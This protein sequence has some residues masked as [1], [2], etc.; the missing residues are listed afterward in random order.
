M[1]GVRRM[2]GKGAPARI[3]REYPNGSVLY[4]WRPRPGVK[5][6]TGVGP[7]GEDNL[8]LFRAHV[9]CSWKDDVA[10]TMPGEYLS[11]TTPP[12]VPITVTPRGTAPTL[13]QW[14]GNPAKGERGRFFAYS[15]PMGSQNARQYESSFRNH[16]AFD[17]IGDIPMDQ[18]TADNVIAILDR[19]LQCPLCAD[20]AALL[21]PESVIPE[22]AL[23]VDNPPFDKVKCERHYPSRLKQS[24][25]VRNYFGELKAAFN[26]AMRAEVVTKNPF[27]HVR[28]G[29][30]DE[31]DNNNKSKVAL[32]H[33]QLDAI[34]QAHPEE[35]RVIP[36]LSTAG[37]F[38][39][40][41]MWGL[42]R[43]DFPVPPIDP[44]E[45]PEYLT[46]Q[47][48]RVWHIDEQ[49]F[50]K[51]GK[52]KASLGNSI[53]IGADAVKALNNHLRNHM[54]PSPD[55]G[56]CAR[57]ERVWRVDRKR[58]PH[59]A[60]GFANDAPL[61]TLALCTPEDYSEKWCPQFQLVAGLSDI[62]F[63]ITHNVF[64]T[65]GASQYLDAGVAETTVVK[66]GRW[67]NTKTLQEHY[68]R[69][70]DDQFTHANKLRDQA[71]AVELGHDVS[72]EAPILGQMRFKDHKI[73]A[74]SAK[75]DG[76]EHEI[77]LLRIRLNEPE[78][79]PIDLVARLPKPE[80]RIGKWG[81]ITDHEIRDAIESASSQLDILLS[82]RL[83]AAAKNYDRLRAEAT[84]LGIDLPERWASLR[85]S[86]IN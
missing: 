79:P 83:S 45:D 70:N 12:S 43:I 82:L 15:E 40:E 41:E 75:C 8:K 63:K 69:P 3:K 7:G 19:V 54:D 10:P 33:L 76:L 47:L 11:G 26:A 32:T 4:E 38:R 22:S 56:A 78:R 20:R 16:G 37:M 23:R 27:A 84:R 55:C 77:A 59:A 34:I 6:I 21:S 52:T 49:R 42:Q 80:G 24:K 5:H 71:R 31:P 2:G 65:T 66:M 62:G 46:F 29:L 81:R 72:D 74:L 30:W 25:S 35:M 9:L 58:N 51:K 18:V 44:T 60:C 73:A 68:N 28:Y 53:T 48:S 14:I 1:V 67:T 86:T 64:R 13:R 17:L 85:A 36:S 61:I 39:R 57:G 50:I